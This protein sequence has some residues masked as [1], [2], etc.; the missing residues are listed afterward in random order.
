MQIIGLSAHGKIEDTANTSPDR[1]LHRRRIRD[2][3]HPALGLLLQQLRQNIGTVPRR[4]AT[5][6]VPRVH[7]GNRP[8][9]I[10][11]R[12][13]HRLCGRR[14]FQLQFST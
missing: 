6:I 5:D 14:C 9:S 3:H 7:Q 11:H 13:A 4:S 10:G 8:L 12:E 1:R 2:R